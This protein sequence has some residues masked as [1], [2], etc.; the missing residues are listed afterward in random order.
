M[1]SVDHLLIHIWDALKPPIRSLQKNMCILFSSAIYTV[2]ARLLDV[3]RANIHRYTSIYIYIVQCHRLTACDGCHSFLK[4]TVKPYILA[5]QIFSESASQ[6]RHFHLTHCLAT[7]AMPRYA[8]S[9]RVIL[10]C[11]SCMNFGVW[12]WYRF[13]GDHSCWSR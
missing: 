3:V 8:E 6:K 2:L 13:L 1:L 5:G 9:R 12:E 11:W 7:G 4:P 10:A